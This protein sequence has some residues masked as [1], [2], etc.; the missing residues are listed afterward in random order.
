MRIMRRLSRGLLVSAVIVGVV[1]APVAA[2]ASVVPEPS[3]PADVEA[4]MTGR[5]AGEV[6]QSLE[7]AV[8]LGVDGAGGEV[9]DFSGDLQVGP[10]HQ[11]YAFTHAFAFGD[12]EAVPVEP[13]EEWLAALIVDGDSVGTVRV[14]K[15]D[16]GAAQLAGFDANSELGGSLVAISED[17]VLVEDAQVATYYTLED[18]VLTPLKA[19]GAQ[20]FS[21]PVGLDRAVSVIAARNNAAAENAKAMKDAANAGDVAVG[22]GGLAGPASD[23]AAERGALIASGV[24]VAGVAGLL[25]Y[26][27][28][29]HRRHRDITR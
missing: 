11:V 17:A 8:D 10:I 9:P 14:W 12:A 16:H 15:P 26:A 20:E 13:V 7:G 21:S 24:A 1:A 4:L 27:L 25:A 23:P 2:F 18:D 3:V 28:M 19:G 6:Q 22:G 29:R 5:I